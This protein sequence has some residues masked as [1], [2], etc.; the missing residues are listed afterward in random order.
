[1]IKLNKAMWEANKAIERTRYPSPSLEDLIN[2]LQGSKIYCKLDMNNAFLQFEVDSS[3]REITT[4]KTHEGLHRFK[5]LNF[6]T[7]AASEILPRKMDEILGNLPNCM[8]IV[9]DVILFATSF[10]T[11]YDA[12]DKVLN[13]FLDCRITLNKQKCKLFINKVE[14]FGFVLSGNGITPS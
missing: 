2:I 1:M 7:N 6:G 10:Y 4:F 8:A 12:L 9:D 5:R 11:M 3:S 13:R 14:F